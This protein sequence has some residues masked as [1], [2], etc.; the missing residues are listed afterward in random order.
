[1]GSAMWER[2]HF[3]S[4]GRALPSSSPSAVSSY[5]TQGGMTATTVRV[6]MSSS[7][8]PLSR[9]RRVRELQPP[10]AQASSVKRR[11]PCMGSQ[12]RRGTHLW[13]GGGRAARGPA[14]QGARGAAADGAGELVEAALALHELVD[15]TRNPLL[16]EEGQRGAD[17]TVGRVLVE[18]ELGVEEVHWR[19][20]ARVLQQDN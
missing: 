9:S 10:T 2:P 16:A 11:V 3:S 6:M 13:P 5:S 15:D 17:G 7:S 1:M 20:G 14:A 12:R 8:R 4:C 19:H 18:G